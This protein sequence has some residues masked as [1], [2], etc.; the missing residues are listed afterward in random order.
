MLLV[1]IARK[2][3]SMTESKQD[4]TWI[5]IMFEMQIATLK[6]FSLTHIIPHKLWGVGTTRYRENKI[7]LIEVL[8][9]H[10]IWIGFFRNNFDRILWP[11]FWWN[12][13]SSSSLAGTR[14]IIW[15]TKNILVPVIRIGN[16]IVK[17][18]FIQ[19]IHFEKIKIRIDFKN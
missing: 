11:E 9:V 13:I 15:N 1:E 12:S 3:L 7:S 10:F 19:A 17:I 18:T 2:F 16:L 14:K 8:S 5:F 4:G 6:F